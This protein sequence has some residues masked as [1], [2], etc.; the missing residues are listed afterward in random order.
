MGTG[1]LIDPQD[2]HLCAQTP[3]TIRTLSVQMVFPG[4]RC[5]LEWEGCGSCPCSPWLILTLPV[6]AVAPSP[7]DNQ[8][9]DER[10]SLAALSPVA[11]NWAG[12]TPEGHE[13]SVVSKLLQNSL[14]K[15]YGKEGN[16]GSPG[17]ANSCAD[18]LHGAGG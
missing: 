16:P 10:H 3:S 1:P 2:R 11:S 15:A 4:M 7:S 13:S 12:T 9:G 5:A 8:T 18:L 17:W 14:D 6:S